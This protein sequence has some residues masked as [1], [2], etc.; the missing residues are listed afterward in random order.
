[1][2][3][4]VAGTLLCTETYVNII[5][6]SFYFECQFMTFPISILKAIVY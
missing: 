4:Q 5:V 2:H 1:M 3:Y 6:L